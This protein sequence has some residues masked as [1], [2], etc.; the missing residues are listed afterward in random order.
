MVA[1]AKGKAKKRAIPVTPPEPV[2]QEEEDDIPARDP[3]A[4][5]V[6]E[7][8]GTDHR[9]KIERKG[10]PPRRAW[11]Y[12]AMFDLSPE[13]NDDIK[14]LAGGGQYRGQLYGPKGYITGHIIRFEIAG[15]AKKIKS[16]DDDEADDK[17]DKIAELEKKIDELRRPKDGDAIERIVNIIAGVTAAATPLITLMMNNK[18]NN[19]DFAQLL[20][21]EERGERRGLRIG[22]LEAGGTKKDPSMELAETFLPPLMKIFDR[23]HKPAQQV[24]ER[25]AAGQRLMAPPAAAPVHEI[26]V[27]PLEEAELPEGYEWLAGVRQ[28]YPALQTYA[29]QNMSPGW[30]ADGVLDRMD[31]ELQHAMTIAAGREDFRSVMDVELAMIPD[32]W[33]AE[34]LDRIIEETADDREPQAPT[35]T[36]EDTPKPESSEAE[37]V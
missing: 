19:Q 21:A 15:E 16:E 2:V 7:F 6:A 24:R 4:E 33:R 34:F 11:E 20:A 9:L 13:L 23:E 3:I 28:F 35:E 12:I 25:M 27:P 37:A 8:N 26:D 29:S 14:K 17:A 36:P 22:V 1:K 18:S 5:L 31:D 10:G 32:E 30:I